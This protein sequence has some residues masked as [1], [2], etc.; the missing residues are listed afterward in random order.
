[1]TEQAESAMKKGCVQWECMKKLQLVYGGRK[2]VRVT[3]I[4]DEKGNALS[5]PADIKMAAA[6]S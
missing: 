5:S 3:T 1:M 4:V 6:F 2:P